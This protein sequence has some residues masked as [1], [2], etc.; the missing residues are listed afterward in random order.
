MSIEY[1]DKTKSEKSKREFP[2]LQDVKELLLRLRE[3]QTEDCKIF[4]NTYIES[5]YIF[6][7]AD[8]KLYSPDCVTRS[9]QRVLKNNN[10]PKMRFHDLRHSTASIL[11]DK[12]WDLKA[13]QDWLGH[14]DIETTL[15]IYTHISNQRK[16]NSAKDLENTFVI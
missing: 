3:Q 9:F 1:K 4:G 2:L 12:G 13:I 16:V 14:S 8:G 7:W 15:N 5:E 11:Y 10:L 6:K